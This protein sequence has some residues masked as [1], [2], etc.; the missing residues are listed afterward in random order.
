MAAARGEVQAEEDP[1]QLFETEAQE[2]LDPME[3]EDVD[4]GYMLNEEAEEVICEPC[5]E[6]VSTSIFAPLKPSPKEV[7]DHYRTHVPFRN[8]CPVCIK[9]KAKE[10]PHRRGKSK[11]KKGL[12]R[13]GLDYAALGEAQDERDCITVLVQ[14][15]ET[16]GSLFADKCSMKGPKDTWMVK[17]VLKNIEST[18]RQNIAAVTDGEPALVA[19]QSKLVEG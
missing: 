18:G 8:W 11:T 7:A 6:R 14:K 5:E 9:A 17:R 16:T 4:G 1:S 12:P 2:M 13:F 3:D 19:V 10:A 15:D